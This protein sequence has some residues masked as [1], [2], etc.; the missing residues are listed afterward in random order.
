MCRRPKCKHCGKLFSPDYRNRKRQEY[1]SET[2]CRRASKAAAQRRWSRKPENQD[3][4]RGPDSC[5]R[6]RRW[7][8]A[9]PGY[10]RRSGKGQKSTNALQDDC[11]AQVVET[12]SESRSYL[13]PALQDICHAQ[14][15]ILIAL[16]AKFTG[17]TLQDDIASASRKLVSLGRDIAGVSWPYGTEASP[18]P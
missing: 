3:Y 7:R 16:I 5:E 10:W 14:P 6:V 1:C 4:F 12:T 18:G 2:P 17:S 13:H 15:L 8:A 11:K 9:N